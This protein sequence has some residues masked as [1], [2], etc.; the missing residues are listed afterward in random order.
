MGS[1][2]VGDKAIVVSCNPDSFKYKHKVGTI[3]EID[4]A[5]FVKGSFIFPYKIKVESEDMFW[6]RAIPC[7]SLIEELF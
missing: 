3:I 6:C 4:P 7:S 5:G 2:K 1:L